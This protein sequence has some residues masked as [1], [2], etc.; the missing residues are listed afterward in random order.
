M[1]SNLISSGK[2]QYLNL[3]FEEMHFGTMYSTFMGGKTHAEIHGARIAVWL[4]SNSYYTYS[5]TNPRA[6]CV[7]CGKAGDEKNKQWGGNNWLHYIGG[8]CNVIEEKYHLKKFQRTVQVS[9]FLCS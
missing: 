9:L 4:A 5:K 8:K 3:N 1:K 6:D 7:I 2:C